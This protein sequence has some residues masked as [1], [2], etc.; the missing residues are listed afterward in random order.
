MLSI[1]WI[2]PPNIIHP[3][4]LFIIFISLTDGGG[5]G[6]VL[7][8]DVKS[9][10][11]WNAKEEN[12]NH[13]DHHDAYITF[14][15]MVCHIF[16]PFSLW[17]KEGDWHFDSSS[18][19]NVTNDRPIYEWVSDAR[20]GGKIW[21]VMHPEEK[22]TRGEGWGQQE[23]WVVLNCYLQKRKRFKKDEG[24]VV[25]G[26]EED[27]VNEQKEER[28]QKRRGG[29]MKKWNNPL[30]RQRNPLLYSKKE[31]E[32]RSLSSRSSLFQFYYFCEWED[33]V[34]LLVRAIFTSWAVGERLKPKVYLLW[35][36]GEKIPLS[37]FLFL[38]FAKKSSEEKR[39]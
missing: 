37:P 7:F 1:I 18:K 20:N 28:R 38:N 13:H 6:T 26:E 34:C 10:W 2:I 36:E 22:G 21:L 23:L 12:H 25:R 31:K 27:S 9:H 33:D 15:S 3:L 8:L 35:E 19:E 5:M 14:H 39:G 32:E 24:M 16:P 30:V 17:R 29:E 4:I 11:K